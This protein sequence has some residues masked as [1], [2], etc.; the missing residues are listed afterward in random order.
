MFVS[1][2]GIGIVQNDVDSANFKQTWEIHSTASKEGLV[3]SLML[4]CA[5]CT[6]GIAEQASNLK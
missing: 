4:V 1:L 6:D 3:A 2:S 5:N